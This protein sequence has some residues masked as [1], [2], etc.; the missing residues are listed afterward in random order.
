MAPRWTDARTGRL[1]G[2]L[3]C[4]VLLTTASMLLFVLVQGW[5]S[6]A[7]NGLHWFGSGGSVDVQIRDI[8]LSGETGTAPVYTFH[9]WP[10]IWSTILITGGAVL[11]SLF[12]SLLVAAFVVEFA[13]GPIRVVLKPVLGLLPPVPSVI[14]GLMGVRVV[15]PFTGTPLI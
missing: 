9:A 5:P 12:G 10:L 11:I 15:V 6:F 14:S 1:L 13:P 3:V 2:T 8:F 7:H 4:A